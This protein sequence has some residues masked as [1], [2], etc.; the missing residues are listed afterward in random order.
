MQWITPTAANLESVLTTYEATLAQTAVSVGTPNRIPGIIANLVA[1]IRGMIA[2]WSPN[3]LSADTTKIPPS[4]LARALVL[5]RNSVLTSVPEYVQSD[6]RRAET[7]AAEEFFLLV[8]KGTIRPE[9]ADDAMTPVVPTQNPS[10]VEIVS[11][12]GSR[13]GRQRM[14][15]V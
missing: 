8:A 5:I 2:T 7:K 3:T 11:A 1:E 6:E 13:T 12:P 10:H 14:Q 15:G 4:F 9:R